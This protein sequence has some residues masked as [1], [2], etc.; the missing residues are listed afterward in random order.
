MDIISLNYTDLRFK[1][2]EKIKS[3]LA[4]SDNNRL[5]VGLYC[6]GRLYVFGNPEEEN[7]F[8]RYR[9]GFKNRNSPPY[10]KTLRGRKA[11]HKP[12]GR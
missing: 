5:T 10:L 1:T 11:R 12:Y 7:R 2:A 9:L 6:R 3:Y 8:R 4:L